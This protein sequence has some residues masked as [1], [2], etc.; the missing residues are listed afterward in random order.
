MEVHLSEE[1]DAGLAL[2]G[3]RLSIQGGGQEQQSVKA[4][5]EPPMR[6]ILGGKLAIAGG[7]QEQHPP[8][9]LPFSGWGERGRPAQAYTQA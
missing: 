4:S 9:V 7:R 1:A 8:S 5:A 2:Q 3:G 6:T